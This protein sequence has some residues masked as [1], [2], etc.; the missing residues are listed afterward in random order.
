MRQAGHAATIVGW[1]SSWECE[2]TSERPASWRRWGQQPDEHRA[3]AIG[4]V[5]LPNAPLFANMSPVRL[6]G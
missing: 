3:K 4:P 1:I 6:R 5:N 2:R